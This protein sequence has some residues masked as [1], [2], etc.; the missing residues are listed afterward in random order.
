MKDQLTAVAQLVSGCFNTMQNVHILLRN[1]GPG[2]AR[3]TRFIAVPGF[4]FLA[5]SVSAASLRWRRCRASRFASFRC[6]E[7]QRSDDEADPICERFLR[8]VQTSV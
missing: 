8:S 4:A 5:R 7:A 2:A 6:T 3:K 1:R